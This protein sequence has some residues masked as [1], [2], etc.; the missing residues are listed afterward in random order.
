MDLSSSLDSS[1]QVI[2]T[3]PLIL[4]VD[5]N[6]DNL[7]LIE[8]AL[9]SLECEI[10][11]ANNG[12]VAISL[13]QTHKLAL[14]LLDIMLPDIDGIEVITRLKQ[15]HQTKLI[16]I[17]AVTALARSEDKEKI[18]MAGCD[19]YLSKPYLLEELEKKVQFYLQKH[20]QN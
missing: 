19:S 20:R 15:D 18:L 14:I 2:E 3:L 12:E 7:W 8:K 6:R 17:I 13:A 11:T 16:P 10:L 5:D 9:E 4:L 1:K